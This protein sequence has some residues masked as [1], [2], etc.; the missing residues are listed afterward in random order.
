MKLQ[1]LSTIVAMSMAGASA[2]AVDCGTVQTIYQNSQ[3][4]SDTGAETCAHKLEIDPLNTYLELSEDGVLKTTTDLH[5]ML[6]DSI[7]TT[8]LANNAVTEGKLATGA[9]TSAIIASNAVSSAHIAAN[10]VGPDEIANA[11]VGPDEIAHHAVGNDEIATDAVTTAKLATGAVTAAKLADGAVTVD[12]LADGAVTV[13]KL[14]DGAVTVDKL[15]DGAV[16]EAKLG[17][18]AVNEAKLGDL[19]VTEA[20]LGNGA[21]TVDKLAPALATK[22]ETIATN[23]A[24]V[25]DI[26][27]GTDSAAL[28]SL[29][30]LVAEFQKMDNNLTASFN[31]VM[32]THTDL[33]TTEA[34]TARA[35]ELA[36]RGLITTEA[37]TARAAEVANRG[38][39]TTEKNRNDVQ[40]TSIASEINRAT[41]QENQ[42]TSALNVERDRHGYLNS[43]TSFWTLNVGGNALFNKE[44]QFQGSK[45]TIKSTTLEIHASATGRAATSGYP[46]MFDSQVWFNK[47]VHFAG[48]GNHVISDRR[49]KKNIEELDINDTLQKVNEIK[50][51][52]YDYVDPKRDGEH[53]T[54][55]FIAQ[56]VKEVFP[57]AT[58]VLH[59]IGEIDIDGE[60]IEDLIGILKDRIFALHHGAIQA[61]D[62][63]IAALTVRL[64][65]LEA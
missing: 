57:S 24:R 15:G 42:I 61:L 37:S 53:V 54:A 41:Y 26:M 46:I 4:C 55:G 36:N 27:N 13:D 51:V 25:D 33:L 22:L 16:N 45:T 32:G 23:K 21:V 52:S 62:A 44:A 56:Q 17:D 11:A 31:L 14:A 3:C 30:E 35:A 43:P 7:I 12:K 58:K 10:A 38:L 2:T 19:Q 29:S 28:D 8:R 60:E 39:I 59:D 20:K 47:Y 18:G 34:S 6:T 65:A 63:K 1:I 49:I 5:N 48:G 9:V 64:A 50:L 40:S